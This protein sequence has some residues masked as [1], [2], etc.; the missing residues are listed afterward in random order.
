VGTRAYFDEVEARKYFVEPHIPRLA[1]FAAWCGK[2]VLEIGCGI[3]TDTINFAR[4]GAQVTAVDL[5]ETSL[6]LARQRAQVFGLEQQ[7][8]FYQADAE[9]LSQVVP[10]E[11]YDLVYSFGVIHHSPHPERILQQ[12]RAHYV[13]AQSTLKVMVYYRYAWKVFWLFLRSGKGRYWEIPQLVAKHSE[14][15]T[16]CPITYI[17]SQLEGRQLLAQ[18]GFNATEVWVDHIFPYVVRDYKDYRYNKEWYF[19]MLPARWFRALEQKFGWH[20]CLTAQVS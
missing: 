6:N 18:A 4:H 9:E 20:L 11:K 3:G 12:V 16:G 14:A 8:R 17:Y 19:R 13:H 10:K 15:Q 5:S 1:D 7:I 2:K